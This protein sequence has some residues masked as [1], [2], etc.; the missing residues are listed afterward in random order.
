MEYN[1]KIANHY[2]THLK[3]LITVNQL[4]TYKRLN[5]GF[6]K[7]MQWASYLTSQT[8]TLFI[9]KMGI[10]NNVINLKRTYPAN[11]LIMCTVLGTEQMPNGCKL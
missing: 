6:K 1:L 2:V 11:T 4:M 9:F 10:K 7:K 3:P 5:A 8:L